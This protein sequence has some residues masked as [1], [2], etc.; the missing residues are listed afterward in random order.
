M[1]L[2]A[3]V[4][5]LLH[6]KYNMEKL[7]MQEI[8][9]LSSNNAFW[10]LSGVGMKIDKEK[11]ACMALTKLEEGK[12]VVYGECREGRIRAVYSQANK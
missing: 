3:H 9:L 11:K 7:P 6:L 10:T 12:H 5:P 1:A 2:S 4:S 8:Y